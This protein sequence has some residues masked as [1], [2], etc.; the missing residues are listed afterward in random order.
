MAKIS[1]YLQKTKSLTSTSTIHHFISI[2]GMQ[3]KATQTFSFGTAE[4]DVEVLSSP[5]LN[6]LFKKGIS[7]NANASMPICV[8]GAGGYQI[9]EASVLKCGQ[10]DHLRW[11]QCETTIC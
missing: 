7:I 4:H 5:C 6:Q 10:G 8:H 11:K 1:G 9:L 2:K 3:T